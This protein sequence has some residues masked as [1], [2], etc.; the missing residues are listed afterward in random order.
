VSLVRVGKRYFSTLGLR[1]V[2]GR[3][4]GDA[5]RTD[6]AEAIVN[7]R[8]AMRFFPD[9]DPIGRRIRLESGAPGSG[10]AWLAIAGV[11]PTLP[12]LM[13]G[14]LAPEPVV[15]VPLEADPAP[16]RLVSLIVR[17]RSGQA[18]LVAQLREDV[19][20]L[21]PDLPLFAVQSMDDSVARTRYPLRMIGSLFGFLA[22]CALLLASVGL[23]ALTAH[24][25]AARTQEVGIRM[26]L[27]A[28][29]RQ[30][31][32]L[33]VQSTLAQLVIGLGLGTAGALA[34]GRLL[35]SLLVET[36]NRD[37]VTLGAVAVL[38]VVVSLAAC[39][40]PAG[41]AAAIDPM[42]ALRHE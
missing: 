4:F 20:A 26:A 37:P 6:R 41:R 34:V 12:Q 18:G 3:G 31:L 27:G 1:L 9:Q 25:V 40:L 8:F 32:W 2:A 19:R 13:P 30:V 33:F 11:V 23:F 7:E 14:Q 22:V 28:R 29:R 10:G 38:L 39:V 16:L 17:E 36:S 15:Y 42:I 21:D 35:E 24:G 5:D